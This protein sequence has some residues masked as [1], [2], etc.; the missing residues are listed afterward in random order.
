MKSFLVD[1]NVWLSLSLDRHIHYADAHR[2]FS[3]VDPAGACFCRLTQLG[4]LRL[5]TNTK[6]MGK[7]VMS[8]LGAWRVYD[9]LCEDARVAYLPEPPA[10]ESDL[11]ALTRNRQPAQ[12]VW[13]DAYLAA[14]ARTRGLTM[15]SFDRGFL[16]MEG[17]QTVI[18]P[19]V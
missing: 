4:F 19:L 16:R 9:R 14:L 7:D 12:G 18:L 13:T 15:V 8:Q 1:I 11:R 6:V 10:M 5:L 17:V 3:S 2:W